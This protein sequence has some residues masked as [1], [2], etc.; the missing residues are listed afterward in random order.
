MRLD[1]PLVANEDELIEILSNMDISVPSRADGRTKEHT[2]VWVASRLLAT[3]AMAPALRG[4]PFSLSIRHQDRPDLVVTGAE[5]TIGIEV[6]EA[7][8]T[9]L[10]AFYALVERERPGGLIEGGHFRLGAPHRTNRDMR[11]LFSQRELS[12][13]GDVGNALEEEWARSIM[14][15]VQ[16]KTEKLT[17]PGFSKFNRNWLAIYNNLD[18]LALAHRRAIGQLQFMMTNVWSTLPG[19][20]TLYIDLGDEIAMV[21]AKG[22]IFLPINDLWRKRAA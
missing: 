14:E 9:Q 17:K 11:R 12:R 1:I 3:L 22:A 7:I 19:F 13:D 21:S 10:S 4:L 5:A 2:E 8:P 6:T 20:D 15:F 18:Y 16:R